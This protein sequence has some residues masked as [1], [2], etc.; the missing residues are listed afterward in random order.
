MTTVI[1]LIDKGVGYIATDSKYGYQNLIAKGPGKFIVRGDTSIG[2]TGTVHH[3][4]LIHRHIP[5]IITDMFS[6]QDKFKEIFSPIMNPNYRTDT[7]LITYGA[8][9]LI[10]QPKSMFYFDSTLSFINVSY[11]KFWAIGA[12]T[13]YALGAMEILINS[14]YIPDDMKNRHKYMCQAINRVLKVC[15]KYN[16]DTSL[17]MNLNITVEREELLD[18]ILGEK[19]EASSGDGDRKSENPKVPEAVL[20]QAGRDSL[21]NTSDTGTSNQKPEANTQ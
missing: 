1:G 10:V 18:E 6:L 7:K 11:N 5:E 17:P 12:G 14:P 15:A 13:E 16:E 21:S 9:A 4:N 8:E 19:D 2:I 20:A 3:L